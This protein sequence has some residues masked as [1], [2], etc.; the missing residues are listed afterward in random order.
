MELEVFRDSVADF[1]NDIEN[2]WVAFLKVGR[3]QLT[4]MSV[5]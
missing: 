4:W 2:S 3:E 5:Y 1:L